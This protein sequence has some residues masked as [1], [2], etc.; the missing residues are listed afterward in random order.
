MLFAPG[1]EKKWLQRSQIR[2]PKGTLAVC[3]SDE[4]QIV[5]RESSQDIFH[6]YS[7]SRVV[8]HI[9]KL[10]EVLCGAEVRGS[11]CA[12]QAGG[13]MVGV[14]GF[15]H[16]TCRSERRGQMGCVF[17]IIFYHTSFL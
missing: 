17:Y 10:Q 7:L 8:S 12:E 15:R 13:S 1:Q 14:S 16:H 4:H 11:A 9:P 2:A 3:F 5:W 6:S